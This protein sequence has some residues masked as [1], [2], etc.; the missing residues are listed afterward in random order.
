MKNKIIG[1]LII[2]FNIVACSEKCTVGNIQVSELLGSVSNEYKLNYC[3]LL[4]NAMEGDK[5][6]IREISLLNFEN[7]VEYDHGGVLINLILNIGEDKYLDAIKPLNKKQK[8]NLIWRLELGIEY[9]DNDFTKKEQLKDLFPKINK[10][11]IE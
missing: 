3:T 6:S 2:C 10:Y 7:A 5:T 11:L 9:G 8:N 1:G 4:E